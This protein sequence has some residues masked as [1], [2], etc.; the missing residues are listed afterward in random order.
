M[1]DRCGNIF[2]VKYALT[3][4]QTYS[5]HIKYGLRIRKGHNVFVE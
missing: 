4:K 5:R 3:K 2:E 1:T